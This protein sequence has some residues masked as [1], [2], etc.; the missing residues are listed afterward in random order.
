MVL[1]SLRSRHFFLRIGVTIAD[2]K[3]CCKMPDARED[4]NRLVREGRI[5]SRQYIMSLE[6]VGSRTRDLG[7]EIRMH[8]FTED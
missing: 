2:L 3:H 4:I 8:S 6:G 5:E 7:A 1:K